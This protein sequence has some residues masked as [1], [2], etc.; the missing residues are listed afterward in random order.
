MNFVKFAPVSYTYWAFCCLL[1]AM[2]LSIIVGSIA[3]SAHPY[4][5]TK[6]SC[7]T[8]YC[9][10]AFACE[11]FWN[12]NPRLKDVHTINC[13]ANVSLVARSCAL[14]SYSLSE[15]QIASPW[16]CVFCCYNILEVSPGMLEILLLCWLYAL[17]FPAL[18]CIK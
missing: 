11:V 1:L 9:L 3:L 4:C 7:Y 17:Y 14:F 6:L 5:W 10:T 12:S 8:L 15:F 16:L 18:L 2:C 13:I